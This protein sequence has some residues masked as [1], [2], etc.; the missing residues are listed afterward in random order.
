MF[1]RRS[2]E[3]RAL[4]WTTLV[5]RRPVRRLLQLILRVAADRFNYFLVRGLESE[6]VDHRLFLHKALWLQSVDY[7]R[8]ATLEL[9]SREVHE[10]SVDG[11][12]AEVGVF[13]GDFARLIN[14]HFPD[15]TLYLFDTFSGFEADD[16]DD[17]IKP[18]RPRR[19]FHRTSVDSVLSKMP[20]PSRVEIRAGRFPE[21]AAGYEDERFCL[22]S[23]DVDFYKPI[24]AALEWF[25]PRLEPG[26]YILVHDYNH[27]PRYEGAKRAVRD[28]AS[29][30]GVAYSV[31]PD[32]GGTAVITKP[33]SSSST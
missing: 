23:V 18:L 5:L 13:R 20:H 9:L 28:F 29:T 17:E 27:G 10:R 31:L 4:P 12:V 30:A 21:S 19:V 15:R 22:V 11:A 3:D 33:G 26:G 32:G 2:P 14:S 6:R 7:V 24:H 1:L 16:I 25:Y 8:I